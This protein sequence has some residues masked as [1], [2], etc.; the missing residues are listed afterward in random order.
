MALL[1]LNSFAFFRCL[2]PSL[3]NGEMYLALTLMVLVKVICP[4]STTA[5]GIINWELRQK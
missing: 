3:C 1:K 4:Y 5:G 2:P